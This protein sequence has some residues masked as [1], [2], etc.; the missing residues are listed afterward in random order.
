MLLR[1]RCLTLILFLFFFF[2]KVRFQVSFTPGDHSGRFQSMLYVRLQRATKCNWLL[3]GR[4]RW[5][6]VGQSEDPRFE[7]RDTK[8][9][10]TFNINGENSQ[11]KRS[12]HHLTHL[13]TTCIARWDFGFQLLTC[14]LFL[15]L[16][17]PQLEKSAKFGSVCF[18]PF[19]TRK[20]NNNI[21]RRV[22]HRRVSEWCTLHSVT[23]LWYTISF[24]SI[25]W[26]N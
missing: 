24:L 17:L 12:D 10:S 8:K 13:T 16:S 14:W 4:R 21:Q 3:V 19:A 18:E 5:L 1:V 22:D 23:G 2:G 9:F 7:I 20:Q 11:K 25:R 26:A 6:M 15:A